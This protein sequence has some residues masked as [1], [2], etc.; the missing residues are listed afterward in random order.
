M[1]R[2]VIVSFR[3]GGTDGVSIEVAKW[4]AALKKVG[5]DVT[6]VAGEGDADILIPGLRAGASE[7]ANLADLQQA[8]EHADLVIVENLASLPLNVSARNVL[9]QALND[10]RSLFHHHDLAWQRPHLAHLDGPRDNDGWHHVTINELSRRQLAERGIV[11]TTIMNTFDCDPP[12][13]D[14]SATRRKLAV[15][16]R[17]LILVPTRAIPRKN[18]DGALGLAESLNAV[19]WLLGPAEDGYGPQ[20]EELLASSNVASRRGLPHGVSIHDAYAACDLVAMPSTWEGFGNPVIESV[21]HLRPLAAYPYPVLK[22]I[23]AFGFNFFDLDDVVSITQFLHSPNNEL[24]KQ[25]LET[26]RLHFN[27]ADLPGRLADLL[28]TMDIK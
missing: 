6:H 24:F 26:A 28:E 21:T 1:A 19:L 8:F 27:I 22:E 17:L 14:R 18:I 7:V 20:L 16:D 4:T 13:G 10:R 5:H 11:A 2:L 9:Y 12:L 23:E 25:N 3:L 15:G